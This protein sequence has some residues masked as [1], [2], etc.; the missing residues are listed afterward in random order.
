MLA[1]EQDWHEAAEKAV[2]LQYRGLLDAIKKKLADAKVF[3]VGKTKL[4]VYI[5][6]KTDEGDWAGVKTVAV[7]T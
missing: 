1:T 2:V 3:K 6:G 5:V 7:E 4:D